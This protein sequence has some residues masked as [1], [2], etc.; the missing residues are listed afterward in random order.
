[1]QLLSGV[2]QNYDW[3]DTSYIANLLGIPAGKPQ[4]E[5]W[6]GAHRSAPSR[7]VESTTDSLDAFIDASPQ[8]LLGEANNKR[9]GQLPF[10]LKVLAA[11]HPLSIQ[12]HPSKTQAEDGFKRE[13]D[14]GVAVDSP[15]RVYRDNNHKPE[16]ICA[17]TPFEAKVGFRSLAQTVQL[18]N[19]LPSGVELDAVRERLSSTTVEAEA[20]VEVLQYP[21][22][23]ENP[24]PLVRAVVAGAQKLVDVKSTFSREFLWTGKINTFFPDDIGVVVALLLN[25]VSLQPHQAVY[26][27]AG[28]LHC[29]LQGVGVELMANSD[30]VVR[31]G[32]TT[33][34]I[35]IKELLHVVSAEPVQ[36]EIDQAEGAVHTFASGAPEF[37]LTRVLDPDHEPFEVDG[38]EILLVTD[39]EIQVTNLSNKVHNLGKGSAVFVAA[40]D[41][42]YRLNGKGVCWRA[43]VGS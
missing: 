19:E 28:N 16:L 38:P 43:C 24:A 14:A 1:M 20:L 26:L 41:Q 29:Y 23:L 32:L 3:G 37:A 42:T 40:D 7:F 22:S 21:L 34:H 4:A 12:S 6:L 27:G 13:N 25:H 18:F 11:G 36:P 31:G 2:V 10:L 15:T 39:G 17:L 35:D 33:K 8:Q 9:Y 5:Y 30:N